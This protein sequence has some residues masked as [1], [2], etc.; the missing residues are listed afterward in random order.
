M[1]RVGMLKAPSAEQALNVLDQ[2]LGP[3]RPG[4]PV[5]PEL[6]R[7]IVL[8]ALH[9]KG[10]EG[11]QRLKLTHIHTGLLQ[12]N[13]QTGDVVAVG[14][15]DAQVLQPGLERFLEGLLLSHAHIAPGHPEQPFG[16]RGGH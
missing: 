9:G 16:L 14:W 15:L 10:C 4:Q 3:L 2:G 12:Q 8:T 11:T 5:Q 6:L 7:F 1:L 13:K